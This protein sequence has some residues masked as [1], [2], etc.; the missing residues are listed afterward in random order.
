MKEPEDGGGKNLKKKNVVCIRKII[1]KKDTIKKN[2]Q[3]PVFLF[4]PV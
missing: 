1:I 4:A 3:T 2:R